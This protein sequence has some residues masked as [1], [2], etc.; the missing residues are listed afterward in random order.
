MVCSNATRIWHF[1]RAW[2]NRPAV[3]TYR[4]SPPL[5]RLVARTLEQEDLVAISA[6]KGS[7]S[8]GQDK[9]PRI[10]CGDR[11]PDRSW[12]KTNGEGHVSR[13]LIHKPAW[14][15]EE[16]SRHAYYQRQDA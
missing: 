7:R 11:V 14:R 6:S 12:L 9:E 8:M 15:T 16:H 1:Q 3:V 13:Y 2:K 10:Y 4:T 5:P